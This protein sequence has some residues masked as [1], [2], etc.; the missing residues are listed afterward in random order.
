MQNIDDNLLV[1]KLKEGNKLAFEQL[2]NKYSGKLYNSISLLLYNKSNAKDI[3]Q[4]SFLIIWEKRETLDPERNFP[5]Y[6]YTIAR[7]LVYKETERLILNNKF[8]ESRLHD[9]ELYDENI[10]ENLNNSHIETRINELV[11]ELPPIPQ[12]IFKLKNVN[13]LSV[14]EIAARMDLTERSVEAHLYRTMKFLKEKLRNF[15]AILIL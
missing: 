1:S 8:M 15:I 6:L 4:S 5:A 3:T 12:E 11:K 10:V 13:E 7:N 9:N 2:Y 14:N